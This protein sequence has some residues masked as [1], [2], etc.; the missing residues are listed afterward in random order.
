MRT[1]APT[2]VSE[3]G[4]VGNAINGK[5]SNISKRIG[6]KIPANQE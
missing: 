6:N 2:T 3:R 4:I 1:S 5:G